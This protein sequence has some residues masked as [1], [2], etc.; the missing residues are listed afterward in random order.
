MITEDRLQEICDKSLAVWDIPYEH[1]PL[2][3]QII[4]IC[5]NNDEEREYWDKIS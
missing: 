5:L 4:R 2:A 1:R 3:K